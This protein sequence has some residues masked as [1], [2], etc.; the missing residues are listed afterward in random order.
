MGMGARPFEIDTIIIVP[1]AF[2]T[3]TEH[4]KHAN[5]PAY[6]SIQAQYGDKPARAA[7]LGAKLE[8]IDAKHGGS[9][10]VSAVGE[11]LCDA[12]ALP[13]NER[14]YRLYVDGQHKGVERVLA[15]Q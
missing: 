9:L 10:D 14:P 15:E 3:G 8:A 2:T 5:Q 6:P 4:F 1:G 13:R 7:T 12:L 11:A